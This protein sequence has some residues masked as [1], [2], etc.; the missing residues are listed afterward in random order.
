MVLKTC[1]VV[2]SVLSGIQGDLSNSFSFSLDVYKMLLA[3]FCFKVK[4]PSLMGFF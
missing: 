3:S 4:L 2:C 1:I